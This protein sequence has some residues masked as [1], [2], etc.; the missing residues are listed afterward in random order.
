[1]TDPA[2]PDGA[3]PLAGGWCW[4]D[5]AEVLSRDAAPRIVAARDLPAEWRD[6]LAD[7]RPAFAG[8]TLDRPRLMGIL[9]VTPDSFSDGGRFLSPDAALSQARAMADAGADIL[10]IGGESTRP[11]AAEVGVEE[12]VSRTAPVIAALRAGGLETPVSIDTR[13]GRVAEAALQAG[14]QVV[15]DVAALS[16]DPAL[17]GIAARAGA[18]VILMHSIRTP[19]TMQDDPVYDDVLLDVYDALSARIAV[20]EAAGIP[21]AR[22]MVDPGIGFGKTVAHNLALLRR[23]SVF[24][25]LGV[26]VLLGASRKRFIGT[27]GHEAQADR[28]MPGSVAVALA[29]LAQGMQ[30]TRVHDVA[31]TKQAFRLWQALN[32]TDEWE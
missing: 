25:G 8:L 7:P 32:R 24:H 17:A 22:I 13:K 4:F 3:L 29:G 18:P 21:R 26:P 6:R 28:R 31:E 10:D 11:G 1:M 9:N 14:A 16:F 27:L 15:N 2:R 30:V 19:A 12:E 5:R 20:A 23:L